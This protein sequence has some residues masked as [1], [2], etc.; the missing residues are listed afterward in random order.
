M[1]EELLNSIK[2]YESNAIYSNYDY[3]WL[4]IKH[5][6]NNKY[7]LLTGGCEN[8]I[9]FQL[10]CL[11]HKQ[12]LELLKINNIKGRGKCTNHILFNRLLM[13]Y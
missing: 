7:K 5:K 10:R 3:E 6:N 2:T 9:I 8:Y 11:T 4:E 1:N 13:S 12:K